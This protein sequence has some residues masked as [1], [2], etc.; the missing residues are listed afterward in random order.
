MD[1]FAAVGVGGG[2][3]SGRECCR[4]CNIDSYQAVARHHRDRRS[5]TSSAIGDGSAEIVAADRAS[6]W[7]PRDGSRDSGVVEDA[8]PA[9][10]GLLDI[11][12]RSEA[13]F[14]N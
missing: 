4:V 1:P 11:R 12:V 3:R 13:P 14:G 7:V 10:T 5:S 8:T 6:K 2:V 9:I